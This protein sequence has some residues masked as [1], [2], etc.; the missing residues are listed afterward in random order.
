MPNTPIFELFSKDEERIEFDYTEWDSKTTNDAALLRKKLEDMKLVGKTISD[1]RFTSH[2]YNMCS[3][4]IENTLWSMTEG[5]HPEELRDYVTTIENVDDYFPFPLRLEMDDPVIIKF[6][7]GSQFEILTPMEEYFIVTMDELPWNVK[8][9]INRENINGSVLFDFCKGK[10]ITSAGL[11]SH[12]DERGKEIVN[13]IYLEW[14][15]GIGRNCIYFTSESHN[16]MWVSVMK[17]FWKQVINVPFIKVKQSMY[18]GFYREDFL[19]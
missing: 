12:T 14:K 3:E 7:D 5:Y 9:K 4:D 1:I 2:V 10:I 17:S 8:G 18:E 16:Y 19:P 13:G 11:D 6:M 15:E